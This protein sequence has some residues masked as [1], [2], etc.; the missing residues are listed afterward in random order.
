[1]RAESIWAVKYWDRLEGSFDYLAKQHDKE[2][3][4]LTR[5]L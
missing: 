4:K 3:D 2:Y 5:S 1:M